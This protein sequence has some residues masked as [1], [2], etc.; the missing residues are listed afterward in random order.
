MKAISE[1]VNAAKPACYVYL[2]H[3]I[4]EGRLEEYMTNHQWDLFPRR[5]L[6]YVERPGMRAVDVGTALKGIA[7]VSVGPSPDGD[8]WF[9]AKILRKIKG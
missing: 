2:N 4:L 3:K 6:F 8:G 7:E 1:M 5:G 9:V